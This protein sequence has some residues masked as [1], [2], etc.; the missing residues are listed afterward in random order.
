VAGFEVGAYEPGDREAYLGLLREAW[1][2]RAV[3]GDEFDWWLGR[4]PAGS[5]VS[6]ARIDGR[7]VGA[8]AHSLLPMVVDGER[9][10]ASW[11]LYAVTHPS[12]RGRGVWAAIESRNERE[13]AERGASVAL[14]FPNDLTASV[15]LGRLG[16][17]EIGRLRAWARPRL[18]QAP[19]P[20][21][22]SP[23]DVPGDAAAGWPN[24]VVR[25]GRHL[26]WR[27]VDSPRGYRTVRSEAGYAVV[28]RTR[29]RGIETAVLADLVGESRDLLRR[30]VSAAAGR[31]MIALPAPEQRPTFISLGFVP[32]PYTL[33]LLGKALTG[34][35]NADPAAWRFTLGDTD[36]F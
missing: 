16:W 26:N 9:R 13:A 34:E 30:A 1:G 36:F 7:V 12:A 29:Y 25:D 8:G 28:G 17:T 22:R 21:D 6:V 27:F 2:D 23:F 35:L 24:H 10:I 11:S 5:V 4:N 14:T 33:R 20:A 18:A 31:L 19:A 32:A 3:S 15:F